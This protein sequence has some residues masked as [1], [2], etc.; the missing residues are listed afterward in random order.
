MQ[1]LEPPDTHYL[2]SAL[3]WLGLGLVADAKAELAQL[4]PANRDHP[5][6]LE[7]R[8]VVCAEEK[9]WAQGLE[10][11]RALVSADP[12]RASGW[13]H[14]AYAL[15]RIPDGSVKRAWDALLPA[16][17]RFPAEPIICYNLSCYA[18]QMNQLDAARVWL[19][20][21]LVIGDKEQL[22]QMAMADSDLE[23]LWSEIRGL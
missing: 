12:K 10:I 14:Q 3:G 9:D 18:C 23:V 7:V 6:A 15:R 1:P 16:F 21:A 19:K 11:A 22:K 20:R 5:D 4:S 17:D 2:S 13:L 8:W